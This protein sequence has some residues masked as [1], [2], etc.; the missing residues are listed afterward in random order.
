MTP[1]M[2]R[3]AFAAAI[4]DA[5]SPAAAYGALHAL[6]SALLPA[7]LVTVTMLDRQNMLARRVYTSDAVAYPT[8]GT[9]PIIED[10]WFRSI[11]TL[12]QTHISNDIANEKDDF[13]DY[14]L[15]LSLGCQ[16]II[17]LP[18]ALG[19]KVVATVNILDAKGSYPAEIAP[20]V[21]DVLKPAAMLATAV[22][23]LHAPA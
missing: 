5:T 6:A 3:A 20:M 16:A 18:V 21:E 1:E 4:A 15:I 19:G 23:M 2:P 14:D 17:N 12:R 7:R 22:A 10:D 13:A 9:K 8:T 11:D